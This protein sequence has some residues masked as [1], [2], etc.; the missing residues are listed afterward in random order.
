MI[1]VD[2]NFLEIL[3]NKAKL[4]F[5]SIK[6]NKIVIDNLNNT[7]KTIEKLNNFNI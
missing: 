1:I 7:L 4:D 5:L 2:D 3:S 6:N